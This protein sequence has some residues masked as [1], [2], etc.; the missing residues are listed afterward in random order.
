[1]LS[2][3]LEIARELINVA[4]VTYGIHSNNLLDTMQ[5]RASTN[6][7]AVKTVK[8]VYPSM[9]ILG[10][11]RTQLTTLETIPTLNDFITLWI[12]LFSHSPWRPDYC[13]VKDGAQHVQLEGNKVVEKVGGHQACNAVFWRY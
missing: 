13:G 2:K 7:V 4:S 12:S 8:K 3:S 9:L 6:N 5:E 1:M 11:S 10:V